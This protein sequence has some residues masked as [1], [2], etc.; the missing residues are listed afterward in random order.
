MDAELAGSSWRIE[1][2]DFP[3]YSQRLV[4]ELAPAG[5]DLFNIV[6]V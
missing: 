1:D 3:A 2:F 5:F 4:V 6:K